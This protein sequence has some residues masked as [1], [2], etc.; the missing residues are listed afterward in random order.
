MEDMQKKNKSAMSATRTQRAYNGGKKK[1]SS[2]AG[3]HVPALFFF[4]VEVTA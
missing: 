1:F 3:H 2:K 4:S